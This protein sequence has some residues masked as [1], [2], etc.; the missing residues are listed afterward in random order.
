MLILRLLGKCLLFVAFAAFAYD[1]ARSLAA[2]GE[3]LLLTSLSTHLQN[4]MPTAKEGLERLFSEYAPSYLW[5]GIVEPM[6]VLPVSLLFG[7]LGTLLFLAG[8]R[9]PPPE[10]LGD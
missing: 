10:I 4:Y 8:Y 9:R 7:A 1:G 2:P 5:T 6:L 3:G